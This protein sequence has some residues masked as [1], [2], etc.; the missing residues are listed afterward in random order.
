MRGVYIHNVKIRSS[1]KQAS[2]Q[3]LIA[4]RWG[5]KIED[6]REQER[7]R[8]SVA[9]IKQFTHFLPEAPDPAKAMRHFDQFLYKIAEEQF[10]DHVLSFLAERDGMSL[11]A[12]L[13]GSS[14]YLWDDFLGIRFNDLLPVLRDLNQHPIWPISQGCAGI[15]MTPQPGKTRRKSSIRSRIP[16]FSGLTQNICCSPASISLNFR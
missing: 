8:T 16:S 6:A 1:G 10:P 11:L 5:R 7:L 9:M 15:L 4:D 13:L 3:F 12:H 2:N 14:D